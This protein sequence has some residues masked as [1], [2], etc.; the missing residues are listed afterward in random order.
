MPVILDV[1]SDSN[2]SMS[3]DPIEKLE[4]FVYIDGGLF[5]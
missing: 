5:R 1:Y 4:D 2:L 3:V